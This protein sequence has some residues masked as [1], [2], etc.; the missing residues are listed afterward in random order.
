MAKNSS[1]L[2]K[3]KEKNPRYFK[4][5]DEVFTQYK[6]PVQL[7]YLAIIES[8]LNITCC[9]SCGCC[10]SLAVYAGTARIL[11]LKVSKEV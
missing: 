11:S 4:I 3:I 6:L 10:R 5:M 7:K 8:E 9:F 1:L 2:A